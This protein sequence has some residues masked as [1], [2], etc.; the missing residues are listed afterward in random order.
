VQSMTVIQL[1]Q[2]MH[3]FVK[4]NALYYMPRLGVSSG[5]DNIWGPFYLE[6]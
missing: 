6:G 2:E 5:C 1:F 4:R 3:S